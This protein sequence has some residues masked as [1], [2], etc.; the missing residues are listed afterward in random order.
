MMIAQNPADGLF[1]FF[2]GARSSGDQDTLRGLG[3][4]DPEKLPLRIRSYRVEVFDMS[5]AERRGEYEKLMARLL[6]L[7]RN[8][9]CVVYKNELQVLQTGTGTGWWRYLEWFEYDTRSGKD[10]KAPDGAKTENE[11][12]DE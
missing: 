3:R 4:P 6:P 8:A 11:E 10:G 7:V 1:G 5:D 12:R 9:Q 2:S